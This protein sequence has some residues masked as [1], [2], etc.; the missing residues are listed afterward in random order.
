[1]I[2]KFRQFVLLG[3]LICYLVAPVFGGDWPT[4]RHDIARSGITSEQIQSPL[5]LNWVF[6]LRQGPEPAW[7]DPPQGLLEARLELRR[8]HFDDVFQPVVADGAVY[9][10]SSAN[11]KVYCLDATTGRIRWTK[12]TGG[13]IRLAPTV[14]G[15]RVFV[16]S[17]DG[18]AYCHNAKDGSEVWK[19]QAAPED[20]RVLGNGK[21]ISLWP[22]RTS[23]LVDNGVVYFG[24]GIFPAEGVFMYALNAEDG[25][26]IWRNGSGG[27]QP[28]SSISPQG[29]L[30]ASKQSILAPMGRTVPAGYSRRDGRQ[31][32]DMTFNWDKAIG[33]TYAVLAGDYYFVGTKTIGMF[34]A[35]SGDAHNHR[36]KAQTVLASEDTLYLA[37][38]QYTLYRYILSDTAPP[39]SESTAQLVAVDR[40]DYKTIRWEIPSFPCHDC[41]ILS[42]DVLIAGGKNQVVAVAAS[43]GRTLW[44]LRVQGRAKG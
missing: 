3:W 34:T 40:K 39:R 9:F 43:S 30:L 28:Q 37:S 1:M 32:F 14:V 24:S 38:G 42:G 16:G 26:L 11:N 21:M 6:K 29:Y 20:Q 44:G 13:P 7:P 17:D 23:L 10:G 27:E 41:L 4:Y 18:W 33:G 35:K 25:R 15:D 12:I 31:L 22:V 19:F 2:P 36:F 5:R 8:T